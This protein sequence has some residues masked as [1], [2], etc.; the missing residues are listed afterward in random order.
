[1][2]DKVHKDDAEWRYGENPDFYDTFLVPER[3]RWAYLQA[4]LN[5][6]AKPFG[7]RLDEALAALT[8]RRT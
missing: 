7:R 8:E 3:A 6:A 2:T 5:D 1:M 4:K